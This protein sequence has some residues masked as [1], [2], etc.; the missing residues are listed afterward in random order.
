MRG[1]KGGSDDK[2]KGSGKVYQGSNG[3]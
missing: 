3:V 1:G 2:R